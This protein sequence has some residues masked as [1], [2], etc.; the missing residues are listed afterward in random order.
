MNHGSRLCLTH[1]PDT[2]EFDTCGLGQHEGMELGFLDC[3]AVW[4][5]ITDGEMM[6]S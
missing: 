3:D 4:V 1:E 6:A 5:N 2:C